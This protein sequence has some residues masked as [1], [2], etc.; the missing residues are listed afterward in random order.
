MGGLEDSDLGRLRAF[1][2]R[3]EEQ[4]TDRAFAKLGFIFPA[5]QLPSW[6][7]ILARAVALA[8]IKPV[9]Y[10]RCRNACVCFVGSRAEDKTCPFCQSDRFNAK[11]RPTASFAY[12]PFTPRLQAFFGNKA[13]A[14]QMRYRHMQTSK[15]GQY[16]ISDVFDGSHYCKLCSE[17]VRVDGVSQTYTHFS[18]AR[19]VALGLST[20]GFNL[21][22]RRGKKSAWPLLL[23]NYNLPPDV[24]FHMK[25]IIS[26][27]I[28]PGKPK[29]VDSY[30]WPLVQE[31]RRLSLGVST[32]DA[33]T[34]DIFRLRA[35]LILIFGDIPAVSMLMNMKGHNGTSPCRMCSIK[36][37]RNPDPSQKTK[38]VPLIPPASLDSDL[39]T[40]LPNALPLRTHAEFM[41]QACQ[42]QAARTATESSRL[43][44]DYGIKGPS[45]LSQLSSVEFPA[46]FPYDFMHLIWENLIPNLV[47]LWT[48]QFKGLDEGDEEYQLAPAIWTAIGSAC[49]AAGSSIPASLGPKPEDL[50]KPGVK[51]T[52]DAWSFWTLYLG[53]I[54]LERRF[55]YTKYYDH[56][57]A[58]VQLLNKCLQYEYSHYDVV[59]IKTGFIQWVKTYEKYYNRD[60]HIYY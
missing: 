60:P 34:E 6:K 20:D 41:N 26:L 45:I 25:N 5:A 27:G 55:K 48:G 14:T 56:F 52:S 2:Y 42:V 54:L 37:I 32:H 44:R 19:D 40:Y 22:R 7:V 18:D 43:A 11:G 17:F 53:P 50:S 28:I 38:Y 39:P 10:D 49:A 1:A 24:R 31:L 23:F 15:H 13:I 30:L 16:P 21:F 3:V 58:L 51:M 47:K 35:F 59:A 4:L 36:A 8:G 46:S 9:L 12:L 29:D 57:V 33:M